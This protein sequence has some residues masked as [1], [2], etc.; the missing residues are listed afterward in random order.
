MILEAFL[1]HVRVL[2][3]FLGK[4][5]PRE[6]DVLA[7]DYCPEYEPEVAISEADRLDIDRRVAHLTLRRTDDFRWGGRERLQR[8]VF[9]Q[10]RVFMSSL[11]E[12]YPA[13]VE[14]FEPRFHGARKFVKETWNDWPDQFR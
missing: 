1:V 14:W 5:R 4:S 8:D 11:R 12:H 9:R 7:V 2:D 10:F 13:R 3:N 6:E